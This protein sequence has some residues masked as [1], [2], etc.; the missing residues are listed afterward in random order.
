VVVLEPGQF[1]EWLRGGSDEAPETV[2]A[3]L[4]EQF[5]CNNC[6]TGQPGARGPSLVGLFGRT[7]KLQDGTEV[8]ADVEYLR[9][10]ILNPAQDLVAGYT[11]IMPLYR[12]QLSEQDVLHL[13]AYLRTL[14]A[15]EAAAPSPE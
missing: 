13:I 10:S 8:Q 1:A 4:F 11:N 5:R 15:P 3:R 9:D 14:R 2:G 6:H 12:G 7:E